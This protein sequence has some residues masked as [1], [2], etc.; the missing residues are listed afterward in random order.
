MSTAAKAATPPMPIQNP[1][2]GVHIPF[3][4]AVSLFAWL[5]GWLSANASLHLLGSSQ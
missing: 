2:D 5:L 4:F 3:D 1:R